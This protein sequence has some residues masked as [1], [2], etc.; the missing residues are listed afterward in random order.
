MERMNDFR[1]YYNQTIHPELLRMELK[2]KRVVR[3]SIISTFLLLCLFTI[4]LYIN[5][6]AITLLVFIISSFYI[7]WIIYQARQFRFTFKPNVIN[8]ILYFLSD[9]LN[10]RNFKYDAKFFLQR[11]TFLD[12]KIF[13]TP[14]IFYR[15][16]DYISGSIG[17]VDFELCEIL[18]QDISPVN[19]KLQSI[20]KGIFLHSELQEE[21]TEILW[22]IPKNKK[23]FHLRA[24]EGLAID[25]GQNVDHLLQD[26]PYLEK[27]TTY[28]T[29][30]GNWKKLIPLEKQ[31]MIAEFHERSQKDIYLSFVQ[32]KVYLFLSEP[33]DFL[34]PYLLKSNVSFELV[35][36]FFEDLQI[37]L[38][39][40]EDFDKLY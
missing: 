2:R 25:G 19:G 12:S 36:D 23:Q 15:G 39:I 33:K 6:L 26:A 16:E 7:G 38:T 21:F 28:A 5:I 30:N 18:V 27:F 29:Q 22:I 24:I 31:R 10:Y 17:S 9:N 20:F 8:L 35:R 4:N 37:V 13:A 34:E 14:A 1:I 11:S 3:L 40:V 32:N